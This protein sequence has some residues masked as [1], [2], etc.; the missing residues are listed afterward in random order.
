MLDGEGFIFQGL[1]FAN[2]KIYKEIFYID[3]AL[4]T[5][6]NDTIRLFSN[7]YEEYIVRISQGLKESIAVMCVYVRPTNF[8]TKPRFGIVKL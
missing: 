7:G 6:Y 4:G 5:F 8:T 3:L 2:E 1:K